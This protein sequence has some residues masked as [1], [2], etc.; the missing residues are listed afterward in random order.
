MASQE[1]TVEGHQWLVREQHDHPG[2]YDFEWLTGPDRYGFSIGSS[3][4][5]P[6]TVPAMELHIINF[7]AQIDPETGYLD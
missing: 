6:M 2:G 7:M 5:S 4:G 1:L 3:D